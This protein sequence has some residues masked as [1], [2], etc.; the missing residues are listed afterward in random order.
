M[1]ASTL[2]SRLNAATASFR[3]LERQLADPDVAADPKRLEVKAK[4]EATA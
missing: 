2:F 3:N 4:T 1:D